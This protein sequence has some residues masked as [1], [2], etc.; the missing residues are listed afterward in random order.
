MNIELQPQI[1]REIIVENTSTSNESKNSTRRELKIYLN[2]NS[3]AKWFR[4]KIKAA[5]RYT[6]IYLPVIYF[7]F[8]SGIGSYV[9][10]KIF[11][12]YIKKH[13]ETKTIN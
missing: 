2:D 6:H 1:T 4:L 13:L 7:A 10:S 3:W 5:Y 9:G 8:I 12:K 11:K